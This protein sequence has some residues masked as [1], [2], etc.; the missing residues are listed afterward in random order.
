VAKKDSSSK[1]A[2]KSDF[3][4]GLLVY[5][6][7]ALAYFPLTR[8]LVVQTVEQD[9][10]LHAFFILAMAGAWLVYERR[11]ELKPAWVWGRWAQGLLV[12]SYALLL[13]I[14]LTGL[15]VL[16]IP[17]FCLAI[18]SAAIWA[19]GEQIKRF[20][21]A[22]VG[23]FALFQG[24]VLLLP[25]VDWPLRTVAGRLSGWFLDL[26]GRTIQLGLNQASGEPT[27]VLVSNGHPFIVAPECN[28]FGVIVSSLLLSLLLVLYRQISVGRKVA[29]WIAAG[30]AG[31]VFNAIRITIIVLLAPVVGQERYML[32]HEIVGTIVYYAALI[33]IWLA[34]QR[35]PNRH[36]KHA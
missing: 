4:V 28:G 23:A 8:F 27:L 2:S 5:A 29:A 11:V 30:L 9:Q 36:G 35:I 21:G 10:L 32:M 31:V 13:V 17:S 34:I 33:G 6:A 20:I 16:M 14:L 19:F 1:P 22:F 25:A 26:L 24:F 3:S 7:S 12:A 18:A 15:N